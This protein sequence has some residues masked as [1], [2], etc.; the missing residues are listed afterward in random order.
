M[1]RTSSTGQTKKKKNKSKIH[2]H[3]GPSAKA[4]RA[5]K[6]FCPVCDAEK[7]VKLTDREKMAEWAARD[8]AREARKGSR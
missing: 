4:Y 3:I 2:I 5:G 1:L 6:A 8:A 7:I